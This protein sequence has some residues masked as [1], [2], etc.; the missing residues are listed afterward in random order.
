MSTQII[1]PSRK[2]IKKIMIIMS[3]GLTSS[4]RYEFDMNTLR[5][6]EDI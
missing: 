1:V 6:S 5:Q 3:S 4:L 2:K